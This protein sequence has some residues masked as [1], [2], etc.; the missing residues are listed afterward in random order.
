MRHEVA[1]YSLLSAHSYCSAANPVSIQDTFTVVNGL[2]FLDWNTFMMTILL[3]FIWP[4]HFT[5]LLM[6]RELVGNRELAVH[7]YLP[8]GQQQAQDSQWVFMRFGGRF[9]RG[10][11]WS[12]C[13]SI[14]LCGKGSPVF[15]GKFFFFFVICID[16]I[17]MIFPSY[18][19]NLTYLFLGKIQVRLDL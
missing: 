3:V 13:L 14:F 16:L 7:T 19:S 9:R 15:Q 8:A 5:E 1:G 4:W 6:L 2:S 18:F 12:V 11:T 10:W 17:K